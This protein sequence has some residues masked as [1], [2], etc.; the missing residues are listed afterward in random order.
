MD[1]S[2]VIARMESQ[3]FSLAISGDRLMV[4]PVDQLT[5]QQKTFLRQHKTEILAALK[6]APTP[7]PTITELMAMEPG[8]RIRRAVE[9]G[10]RV[11]LDH[12]GVIRLEPFAPGPLPEPIP[13][14]QA[15]PELPSQRYEKVRCA[16]CWHRQATSHPVLTECGAGRQA[17]GACWMWWSLD[18]HDCAEFTE[19]AR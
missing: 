17:P 14:H 11:E 16:D 4:N 15:E 13:E 8:E 2:A 5:D 3:G 1:A 6:A 18:R 9:A 10:F 12:D 7:P 19:V